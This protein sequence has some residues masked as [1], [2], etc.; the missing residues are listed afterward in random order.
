MSTL[1]FELLPIA[2]SDPSRLADVTSLVNRANAGRRGVF[3]G[4]RL[5]P[6]TLAG[7]YGGR[8]CHSEVGDERSGRAFAV[9]WSTISSVQPSD[10]NGIY[11]MGPLARTA[12]HWGGRPYAYL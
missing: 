3:P 11:V 4:E 5:R 8:D 7:H 10:A 1:R 6:D 9:D 2:A 12:Q